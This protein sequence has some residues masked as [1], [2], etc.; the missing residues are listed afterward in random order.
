MESTTP[1]AAAPL[2]A[3]ETT[4]VIRDQGNKAAKRSSTS[5]FA[6]SLA[7]NKNKKLKESAAPAAAADTALQPLAA[8]REEGNT[9]AKK[10]SRSSPAASSASNKNKKLKETIQE[11]T[12]EHQD[13]QR[14]F[15]TAP[16]LK[17]HQTKTHTNRHVGQEPKEP[18]RLAPAV[19]QVSAS[20]LIPLLGRPNHF[21]LEGK[22]FELTG[23]GFVP[24]FFG[25]APA[26]PS[27]GGGGQVGSG[28]HLGSLREVNQ[29][30]IANRIHNFP[31]LRLTSIMPMFPGTGS[32]TSSLPGPSCAAL[33]PVADGNGRTGD[34]D[35]LGSMR[36][37]DREG[38]V[39]GIDLTLRL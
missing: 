3:A 7:S 8:I 21:Y 18:R 30:G 9:A 26:Q 35:D 28:D 13:C 36:E 19:P 27:T 16:A 1:A 33:A 39:D 38:I 10:R 2:A 29:G 6:P 37:V 22:T 4:P 32:G 15:L 17:Q 5:C 11:F 14:N 20:S 34:G 31:L 25:P 12:C 24:V 23:S